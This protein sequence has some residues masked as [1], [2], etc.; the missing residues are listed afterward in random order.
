VRITEQTG[1]QKAGNV[2]SFNYG[3]RV[4]IEGFYIGGTQRDGSEEDESPESGP[5]N[6]GRLSKSH[7]KRA[8]LVE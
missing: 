4:L 6:G 3:F 2:E 5:T 7:Y 8:P 1:L